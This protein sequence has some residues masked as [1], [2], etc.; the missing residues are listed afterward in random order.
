MTL[1]RVI[2]GRLVGDELYYG[3][4]KVW[5]HMCLYGYELQSIDGVVSSDNGSKGEVKFSCAT[6]DDA[7]HRKEHYTHGLFKETVGCDIKHAS[8]ASIREAQFH[9][10]SMGSDESG[11][12]GMGRSKIHLPEAADADLQAMMLTHGAE[13]PGQFP[14]ICY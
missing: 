1:S 5:E 12:I 7:T 3:A 6:A 14:Q 11:S 2:R 8:D 9:P 4:Y 10:D 13:V